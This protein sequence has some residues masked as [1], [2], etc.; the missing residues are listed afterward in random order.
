M[1]P[2]MRSAIAAGLLTGLATGMSA[3]GLTM[4]DLPIPG[5]GVSGDTMKVQADF[6]DAL[7]LSVGAPVKINGVSAGKVDSIG[8]KNFTAVVDLTIRKDAQLHKGASSS[9]T[10]R[11]PRP[12][13]CSPTAPASVSR[14]RRQRRRS[15]TRCPRHRCSSTVVASTSCRP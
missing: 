4:S 11:T 15:R 10:S 1:N 9:S 8:E 3:C 13:R 7:N 5:T 12:V 14:T 6:G 2:R